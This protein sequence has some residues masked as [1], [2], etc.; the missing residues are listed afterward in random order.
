MAE[1][2]AVDATTTNT[3]VSGSLVVSSRPGDCDATP[4]GDGRFGRNWSK[5]SVQLRGR[6]AITGGV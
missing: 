3:S 6:A 1:G 4:S 5:V 2:D